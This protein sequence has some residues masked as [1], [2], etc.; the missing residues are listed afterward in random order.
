MEFKL[1][2][3]CG[4]AR[5]GTLAFSGRDVRVE[6]PACMWLTSGGTVPYLTQDMMEAITPAAVVHASFQSMY[7]SC[8][9]FLTH[10]NSWKNPGPAVLEQYKEP[11][12]KFF[13]LQVGG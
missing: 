7:E 3:E 12:A 10:I 11:L 5:C 6:T 13:N 4:L 9:K 8:A 1:T 2:T